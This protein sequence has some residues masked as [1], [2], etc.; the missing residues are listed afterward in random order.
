MEENLHNDRL[1]D[2]LKKSLE[3][4]KEKPSDDVWDK[5]AADLGSDAPAKPAYRK[6]WLLAL[7]LLIP[8]GVIIYQQRSFQ[9]Q[10]ERLSREIE[11]NEVQIKELKARENDPQNRSAETP[12]SA[13][14]PQADNTSAGQ[15]GS[16][17]N[18]EKSVAQ[19]NE[20]KPES[21]ASYTALNPKTAPAA[22]PSF[23]D[24][25]PQ[26]FSDN[27]GLPVANVAD[28]EPSSAEILAALKIETPQT[29]P[30]R[31]VFLD[32]KMSPEILPATPLFVFENAAASRKT[33]AKIGAHITPYLTKTKIEAKPPPT[34]PIPGRKSFPVETTAEGNGF[35]AGLNVEMPLFKNLSLE[36]GI[37]YRS[38]VLS[39]QHKS[40]FQYRERMPPP[41]AQN[42]N[43]RHDFNYDLNAPTG[44]YEITVRVSGVDSSRVPPPDT[45]QL[46]F[47]VES[48]ETSQMVSIPLALK[49][50]LGA[51]RWKVAFKGGVLANFLLK[52][53]FEIREIRSLNPRFRVAERLRPV[54][55]NA[56]KNS[57][58]LDYLAGIGLEYQIGKS[59]N[60]NLEPVVT[61]TFVDNNN[62][63]FL[64]ISNTYLGLNAGISY[65]F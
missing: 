27:A 62:T 21:R 40:V 22:P 51:G 35:L 65:Q 48:E 36:S 19:T 24:E 9:N 6:R 50:R 31:A 23:E 44:N 13:A 39:T 55:D 42:P 32:Y 64:N 2:F 5:I 37:D 17:K 15:T 56:P 3:G 58:S 34:R 14:P 16:E 52:S 38:N 49:Y 11:Q 8:L 30:L 57:F 18:F 45:E 26:I 60:L 47:V 61:G 20:S 29:L 43:P 59:W 63:D 53:D 7:L 41:G 33:G 28:T 12:P 54:P 10:L 4:H 25:T 1:E 46:E